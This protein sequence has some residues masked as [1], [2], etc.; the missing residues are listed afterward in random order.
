MKLHTKTDIRLIGTIAVHRLLP[1]HPRDR[2]FNIKAQYLFKELCQKPFIHLDHV[3]HIHEGQ[4]HIDL[5]KFSL[6][7]SP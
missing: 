1:S 5:G 2:K 3:V 6:T 4:F 7:V